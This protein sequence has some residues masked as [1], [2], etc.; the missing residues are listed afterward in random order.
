MKTLIHTRGKFSSI[1][2][3]YEC[4]PEWRLK[5]SDSI[6]Y[7]SDLSLINYDNNDLY[8]TLIGQMLMVVYKPIGVK[9]AD[10][11]CSLIDWVGSPGEFIGGQFIPSRST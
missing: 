8:T 1:M 3:L 7:L 9:R 4:L 6:A 5:H 10:G 2:D 11:Y